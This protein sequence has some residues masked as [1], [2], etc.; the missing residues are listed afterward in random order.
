M[1]QPVV[2]RL[3]KPVEPLWSLD[4]A[5][6]MLAV[7]KRYLHELIVEAG[8]TTHRYTRD[9]QHPRRVRLLTETELKAV[10][11]VRHAKLVVIEGPNKGKAARR[12]ADVK[13]SRSAE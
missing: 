5:A 12:V 8:I 4:V 9:H 3:P 7:T 11:R 2:T 6:E 1:T 13:L 10:A